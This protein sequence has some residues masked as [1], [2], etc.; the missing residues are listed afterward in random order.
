[1]L[2]DDGVPRL[3]K[4][5]YQMP[6]YK[7]ILDAGG[8]METYGAGPQKRIQLTKSLEKYL[9]NSNVAYKH[10]LIC[11]DDEIFGDSSED[12]KAGGSSGSLDGPPDDDSPMIVTDASLS[13]DIVPIEEETYCDN[14]SMHGSSRTGEPEVK[15]TSRVETLGAVNKERKESI[16]AKEVDVPS[17]DPAKPQ[18]VK[19]NNQKVEKNGK[20]GT[21]VST[22][23]RRGTPGKHQTDKKGLR[24]TESSNPEKDGLLPRS[25][26]KKP[27][28]RHAM[29]QKPG[30]P[31]ASTITQ[32]E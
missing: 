2:N 20:E 14:A 4:R 6:G 23:T 30:Q 13:Q 5:A 29:T 1:M 27:A 32:K 26:E 8:G 18:R 24:K 10:L 17:P 19:E 16:E 25:Q 7:K 9:Q 31:N 12:G 15:P 22:G 11:D 21:P 28:L 3:K